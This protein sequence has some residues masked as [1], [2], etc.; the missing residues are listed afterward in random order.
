MRK[1]FPFV[2]SLLLSV[3]V[4]AQDDTASDDSQYF[5]PKPE[6]H[7]LKLGLTAGP[8][9][10]FGDIKM[11]AYTPAITQRLG[12][13][14][15]GEQRITPYLNLSLDLFAGKVYGE[16]QDSSVNINFRT[17]IFAPSLNLQYNFKHLTRVTKAGEGSH[18][19]LTP[20]VSV[21]IASVIYRPK[22]DLQNADGKTYHYWA[23]GSIKDL[24]ETPQNI[25]AATTITRDYEYE[26]ELRDLN[27]D[28]IGKYPLI[29]LS[30]PFSAGLN[31]NITKGFSIRAQGTYHLTFTDHIDNITADGVGAR[32]G[33]NGNDNYLYTSIGLVWQIAPSQPK[34]KTKEPKDSDD[35]EI[36]DIFDKGKEEKKEEKVKASEEDKQE[37]KTAT[38]TDG[39]E[40]RVD[41][42]NYHW[43]DTDKNGRVEAAEVYEM[44]DQYLEG[45]SKITL[46]E[47]NELLEYYFEQD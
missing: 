16:T 34:V 9:F 28:G 39:S 1:L 11:D 29:G 7:S 27:L 17:S 32:K 43:A 38:S 44:I 35:E 33:D 42:G 21:G 46:Q 15:F 14:F 4:L 37:N 40:E 10:F 26:T 2:L 18:S 23:D 20:F 8:V 19:L 41:E 25:D 45:D 31:V 5:K 30:L 24:P 36:A 22:A 13:S 3:P 6:S 12:Y 47:M